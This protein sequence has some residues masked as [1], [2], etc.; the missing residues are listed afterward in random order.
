MLE[1]SCEEKIIPFEY[2]D[3]LIVDMILKELRKKS[4]IFKFLNDINIYAE[5]NFFYIQ[6]RSK[7]L[8][9]IYNY[10]LYNNVYIDIE[11][12][13]LTHKEKETNIIES[14]QTIIRKLHHFY[15]RKKYGAVIY[16]IASLPLIKN[17]TLDISSNDMSDITENLIE[18]I[19][20]MSQLEFSVLKMKHFFPRHLFDE[21]EKEMLKKEDLW[22]WF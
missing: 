5:I 6:N 15:Q 13:N 8:K 14:F 19:E 7:K 9:S 18:D 21:E 3:L 12:K 1:K 4:Y 22:R 2:Y 17:I 20:E 10:N 11:N 16:A